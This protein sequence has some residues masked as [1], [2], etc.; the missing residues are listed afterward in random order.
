[1]SR[2]TAGTFTSENP[3]GSDLL[4][5]ADGRAQL[6]ATQDGET[7]TNLNADAFG[8]V[9]TYGFRTM[10]VDMFAVN[11]LLIFDKL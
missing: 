2:Q 8:Q 10:Q 7:W 5:K 3:S 4:S 6:W 11:Q 9:G 1:L